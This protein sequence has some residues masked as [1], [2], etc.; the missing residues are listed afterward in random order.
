MGQKLLYLTDNL[1][2]HLVGL[3]PIITGVP[4][5]ITSMNNAGAVVPEKK[6]GKGCC[7]AE[8]TKSTVVKI[9]HD[10]LFITFKV[11]PLNGNV[12]IFSLS[13]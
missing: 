9:K 4:E 6:R 5:I 11:F 8:E 13:T 2:R 12:T 10:E 3:A 7:G 1:V